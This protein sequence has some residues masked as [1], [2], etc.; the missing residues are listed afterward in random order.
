MSDQGR[1]CWPCL[2]VPLG[3]LLS[4]GAL[5]F[6]LVPQ[7]HLPEDL[8]TLLLFMAFTGLITIG[9]AY[10]IYRFKVVRW[11]R[12][13]RWALLIAMLLMVL[14]MFVNIWVTAQ[15]MFI[16]EYDLQVTAALLLFAG[17]I[18]IIF[19][20]SVSS[21]I[22]DG[23]RELV[24]AAEQIASGDLTT[25]LSI[26]GNDELAEF[27]RRFN[28]MTSQ[29]QEMDEQE[30]KLEQTRRDLIAWA[31]HD[32]RTPLTALRVMNEAMTDGMV[33]DVAT[34]A[35][36]L[37]NMQSEIQH[38]NYLIDNLFELAQLDAGHLN[39]SF[40]WVSLRDLISDTLE[41][42]RLRAERGQIA[43]AGEVAPGVDMVCLAPD[44]IQ[45]VLNNLLDNAIR[46][47]PH[48]GRVHLSVMER[49]QDV[50]VS[51]N[52]YAPNMP[53][54]EVDQLF[55]RFYRQERARTQSSDGYRGAG[56][57]LAIARGFVEAH[58]GKISVESSPERGVTFAF[59]LPKRD[60]LQ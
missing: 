17:L 4:I 7:L 46:Y 8:S 27:A 1:F 55:N 36:Y 40:E 53:P 30:R 14:L 60:S 9:V 34:M 12:S 18:A 48:G 50:C 56:L 23:I 59:T 49:A 13:L 29:L 31:S 54:V 45:R 52:N 24:R 5:V 57:G 32:L 16:S 11:F 35:R 44:K 43:L 39:L 2:L 20:W 6:A 51:I 19:G 15:L 37:H 28:W 3:V 58:G 10:T 22:T 41:Q 38:L 25:R 47:T 33:S 21:A 42:M 26:T